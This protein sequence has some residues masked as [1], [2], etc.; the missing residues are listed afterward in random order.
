MATDI[1]N[2]GAGNRIIADA[3][4]HDLVKHRPEIAMAWDLNEL[5]WPWPDNSFDLIWAWSVLEH[6]KL[7]LLES[8][9]ECWRIL[10]P[11]GQI[12]LKIPYWKSDV[13]Y[14]DPTHRWA[15]GLNCLDQFDPDT[16]RGKTYSYYT[17]RKWKLIKRPEPNHCQSSII[18]T[19]EVRK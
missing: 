3:V 2:L 14:N 10:R 6:L 17:P 15:F 18:A 11:K 5:P 13:S 4:N 16:W 9:D 12:Y 7:N 19:L 8:L 1:L